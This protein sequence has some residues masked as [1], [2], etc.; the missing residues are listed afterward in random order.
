ML[1]G[2]GNKRRGKKGVNFY[3]AIMFFIV[4]QKFQKKDF[5]FTPV[6]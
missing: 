5:N 6:T 4:L 2:K 3:A 1:R